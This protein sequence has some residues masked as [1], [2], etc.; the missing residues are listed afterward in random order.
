MHI[1]G[2]DRGEPRAVFCLLSRKY[3]EFSTASREQALS[4]LPRTTERVCLTPTRASDPE[5]SGS[6]HWSAWTIANEHDEFQASVYCNERVTLQNDV[7][8][9]EQAYF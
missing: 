2:D 9:R 6:S 8:I 1:R 3:R 7:R 4:P 5:I